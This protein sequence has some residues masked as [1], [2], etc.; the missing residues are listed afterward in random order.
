MTSPARSSRPEL[1]AIRLPGRPEPWEAA[2]FGTVDGFTQ[3]GVHASFGADRLRIAVL[4]LAVDEPELGIERFRGDGVLLRK[5]G[6]PNGVVGLDHVVA[7]TP[8]FEATKRRLVAAGFDHRRD[9]DAVDGHRQA[10]FV[11][12]RSLLELV[13]P[14]DGDARLWGLTLVT[15][16]IERT[17]AYLGDRLGPIKEAVQPGRR[18]ATVRREAGLGVPVAFMTPR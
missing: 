16:D 2:G 8:D 7:F 14:M 17:A 9:R 11:L 13:G 10:F 18:I 5:I 15:G 6:H 1:V 12:G 4:P 3:L